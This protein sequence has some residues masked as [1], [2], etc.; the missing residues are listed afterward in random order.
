MI[1]ILKTLVCIG[2]LTVAGLCGVA[3]GWLEKKAMEEEH[4]KERG[5]EVDSTVTFV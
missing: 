4:E 5:E 3:L 2:M 1:A